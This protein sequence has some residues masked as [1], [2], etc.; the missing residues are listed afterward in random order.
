V[1]GLAVALV[2]AAAV[3]RLADLADLRER[4]EYQWALAE[5]LE[6]GIRAS[7]GRD[8]VLACGR[9]YVGPFRGP[10][11]AYKLDVRKRVVEPDDP[12]RA[13]GFVFRS[14]L[15]AGD[16]TEPGRPAGFEPVARNDHWRVV[17]RCT[18]RVP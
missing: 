15:N 3:P 14:A 13:P 5:G 17:R 1:L 6:D 18:V 9:P 11:M 12:P 10:L 16:P 4:Q 7:G 2:A 8:A